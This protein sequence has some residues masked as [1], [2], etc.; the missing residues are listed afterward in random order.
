MCKWLP[1]VKNSSGRISPLMDGLGLRSGAERA[2]NG[3]MIT[4]LGKCFPLANRPLER[5]P[6]RRRIGRLL[7]RACLRLVGVVLPRGAINRIAKP[8]VVTI[9][10]RPGGAS[11]ADILGKAKQNVSLDSLG[12]KNVRMRRAMSG[13]LVIEIP[14]SNGK[15][16][17]GILRN[18]LE[19]VLKDE[20]T[21][22]NPVALGKVRMRGFDPSTTPEIKSALIELSGCPERDLRISAVNTMRDRMGIAWAYCP[23][24]HAVRIAVAGRE[25]S[26]GL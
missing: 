10:G 9:T 14:G 11:Y 13:A 15:E 7:E 18:S 6:V 22:N 24:E 23:L 3:E 5:S 20:A 4:G 19:E 21:V 17:A 16:Q 25:G 12:I 1:R 8:A 26:D 2:P